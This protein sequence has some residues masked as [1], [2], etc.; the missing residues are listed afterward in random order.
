MLIDT[1]KTLLR[2]AW[3]SQGPAVAKPRLSAPQRRKDRL[4]RPP[5]HPTS[6]ARDTP[7]KRRSSGPCGALKTPPLQNHGPQL[8]NLEKITSNGHL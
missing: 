2:P 4:K 3:R 6:L 5:S 7:S 8:H 1:S